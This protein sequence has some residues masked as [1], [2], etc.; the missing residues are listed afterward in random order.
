M[1]KFCEKKKSIFERN[2][3]IRFPKNEKWEFEISVD[4]LCQSWFRQFLEIWAA[5]CWKMCA[6][7]VS[8]KNMKK[9]CFLEFWFSEKWF[10]LSTDLLGIFSL[11]GNFLKNAKKKFFG[12]KSVKKRV[13]L[14]VV[15]HDSCFW[16]NWEFIILIFKKSR[17]IRVK[18]GKTTDFL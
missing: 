12:K 9:E 18:H 3:K 17:K 5:K 13:R 6:F 10:F 4:F 16:W 14:W 1:L 15:T 8:K 11:F 7:R 2:K